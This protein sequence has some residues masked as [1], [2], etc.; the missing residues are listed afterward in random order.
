MFVPCF[1]MQYLVSFLT[2]SRLQSKTLLTIDDRGSKIARNSFFDCHLSP[3]GRGRQMAIDNIVS[4]DFYLHSSKV[5]SFSITAY[6]N[7]F[8]LMGKR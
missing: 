7:V 2:P 3:V 1:V 8:L 5:L 4:N 6:P